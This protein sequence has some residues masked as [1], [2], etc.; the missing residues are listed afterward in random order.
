[1]QVTSANKTVIKKKAPTKLGKE[2]KTKNILLNAFSDIIKKFLFKK[3]KEIF[4]YTIDKIYDKNEQEELHERTDPLM[5]VLN[6]AEKKLIWLRFRIRAKSLPEK[7][8]PVKKPKFDHSYSLYSK[9]YSLSFKNF[10]K[11]ILLHHL[12]KLK[13]MAKKIKVLSIHENKSDIIAKNPTNIHKKIK[14]RSFL[15]MCKVKKVQLAYKKN[16]LATHSLNMR[17]P[18]ARPL[19]ETHSIQKNNKMRQGS[20]NKLLVKNLRLFKL[21]KPKSMVFEIKKIKKSSYCQKIIINDLILENI[22][23]IVRLFRKFI[24]FNKV[25]YKF[26][27]RFMNVNQISSQ[28]FMRKLTIPNYVDKARKL[29]KD[30]KVYNLFRK[31]RNGELILKRSIV[32]LKDCKKEINSNNQPKKSISKLQRVMRVLLKRRREYKEKLELEEKR[33]EEDIKAAEGRM[34]SLKQIAF[35]MLFVLFTLFLKFFA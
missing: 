28:K 25:I 3:K 31:I 29:Q 35:A 32:P 7:I 33:K 22:A 24:V 11:L 5:K 15:K 16:F 13:V 27:M 21:R 34:L 23:R 14:V 6:K 2:K 19:L 26:K 17:K 8:H 4:N 30:F 10:P 9:Y 1:M 12:I 18:K 20:L